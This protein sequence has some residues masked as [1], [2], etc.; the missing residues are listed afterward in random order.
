MTST[1]NDVA[2][3]GTELAL[4]QQFPAAVPSAELPALPQALVWL[5]AVSCAV[6]VANVYYNQPLLH[7]F[8]RYFHTSIQSAGFVATA[9]QVGYGVGLLFFVPLGDVLERRKVILCL[10]Y[11]C[12]ILLTLGAVSTS[13]P[14]LV[15]AQFLIGATAVNAQLLIPLAVEMSRP[16]RRGHTVGSLMAGLLSG[17]LLARTASGYLGD[18]FGWRAVFWIAAGLMFLSAIALQKMLP[19]RPPSLK[20]SYPKLMQSL[21][22]LACNQPRLRAPSLIGALS[23]A[24]FCAFW[25]VLSFFM[26][27]RHHLGATQTGLFGLV[28]L[29]GAMCA[30][31]AG[32]LSDRK[33]PA[34]TITL[35][36]VLCI[37]AFVWMWIYGSI[38]GLIV[39]VLLLDLGVQSLQVAAQSEVMA[40][41]PEARN[42][43]NTIYMVSR[44][45]GGAMGSTIGTWAYANHGWS[46]TSLICIGLLVLAALVHLALRRA[47]PKSATA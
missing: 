16:D 20:I 41:I 3:E 15:L 38:P 11:A 26:E 14:L 30:P 18:R 46:G 47:L 42:R 17:L 43:L 12:T 19:S 4:R 8:A 35:A 2:A 39:G 33:G 1:S 40:L 44:F 7:E 29:A 23:F 25:A 9:A 36:L 31:L 45:G 37:V 34:F 28:G 27:Q 10:S 21:W 32:R 24:A 6:A 5:M 13:F 22:H